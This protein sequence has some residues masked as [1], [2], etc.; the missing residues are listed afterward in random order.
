MSNRSTCSICQ[1][2]NRA[3]G[4]WK[5]NS[6]TTFEKKSVTLNGK[7][8]SVNRTLWF[9]GDSVQMLW[10]KHLKNHTVCTRLYKCNLTY[11][12]VYPIKSKKDLITFREYDNKDFNKTRFLQ[13]I[14]NILTTVDLRNNKSIL[15]MNFGLHIMMGMSFHEAKDLFDSFIQMIR[16]LKMKYKENLATI[17]WKTIT[18]GSFEESYKYRT[19]YRFLTKQVCIN[20]YLMCSLVIMVYWLIL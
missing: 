10:F 20:V 19:V 13:I 12:W 14:Y 5:N 15:L 17:I 7:Y 9:Y 4:Y 2:I 6:Y 11:N 1:P 16:T 3:Y 8:P 18:P